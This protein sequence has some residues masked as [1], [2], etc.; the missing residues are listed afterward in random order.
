[1]IGKDA[2][3]ALG[4]R[5]CGTRDARPGAVSTDHAPRADPVFRAAARVSVDDDSATIGVALEPVECSNAAFG[6]GVR[7]ARA[8]PFVEYVAIDHADKAVRRRDPAA[9]HC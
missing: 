3:H 1:M 6:A 9:P 5:K 8:E 4:A 2:G 7:G